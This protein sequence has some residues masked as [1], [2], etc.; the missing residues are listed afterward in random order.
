MKLS[1]L[2]HVK[3]ERDSSIWHSSINLTL[4]ACQ[5]ISISVF[6]THVHVEWTLQYED[7]RTMTSTTGTALRCAMLLLRCASSCVPW[8]STSRISCANKKYGEISNDINEDAVCA[9]RDLQGIGLF[10]ST[11]TI[12]QSWRKK[13]VFAFHTKVKRMSL[14]RALTQRQW[15]ESTWT[16]TASLMSCMNCRLALE[17]LRSTERR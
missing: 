16:R 3:F 15:L 5:W 14:W 17:H 1:W 11:W 13:Q 6:V 12:W 10:A 2:S 4:F 7:M 9:L 8:R